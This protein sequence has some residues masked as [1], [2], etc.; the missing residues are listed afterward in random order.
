[1]HLL[2]A[3]AFGQFLTFGSFP[4]LSGFGCPKPA[5]LT[6]VS[7]PKHPRLF[8]LP[9]PA[10][11]LLLPPAPSSGRAPAPPTT[12]TPCMR[13]MQPRCAC[14]QTCWGTRNVPASPCLRLTCEE[15]SWTRLAP[16]WRLDLQ[17][18]ACLSD[19]TRRTD[20]HSSCYMT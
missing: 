15:G 14:G 8:Q 19:M 10:L 11:P 3:P 17:Y 7:G 2:V 5:V 1:M 4:P 16:W 20:F 18:T 9:A 13:V 12:R 6:P